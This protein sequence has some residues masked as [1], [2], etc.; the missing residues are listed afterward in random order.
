MRLREG[1]S[2][3]RARWSLGES[4]SISKQPWGCLQFL[5]FWVWFV[6]KWEDGMLS[7]TMG[8]ACFEMMEWYSLRGVVDLGGSYISLTPL[9]LLLFTSTHPISPVSTP[10]CALSKHHRKSYCSLPS[11][12]VTRPQGLMNTF[13][14]YQRITFYS[15]VCR[16]EADITSLSYFGLRHSC[17]WLLPENHRDEKR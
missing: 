17:N 12:E 5:T 13:L 15:V 3:H 4:P 8:W 16:A 9:C 6:G 7:A 1:R 10:C 2:L 11:L 14:C